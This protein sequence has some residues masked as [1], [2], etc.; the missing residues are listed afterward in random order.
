LAARQCSSTRVKKLAHGIADAFGETALHHAVAG[1]RTSS[2]ST[3][4][5]IWENSLMLCWE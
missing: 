4:M 1:V 3:S 5:P 2:R